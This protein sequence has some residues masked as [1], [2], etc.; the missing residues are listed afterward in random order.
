M[1]VVPDSRRTRRT[2]WRTDA[3]RLASSE[4]NGSSS[5]TSAGSMARPRASATRCCWPP[6]SSC[7]NR[8]ARAHRVRPS[9]AAQRRADRVGPAGRGRSRRSPRRDK[10]GKRLP[11]LRDVADATLRRLDEVRLVVDARRRAGRSVRRSARSKPAITR[12]SVVLPL[13][14]G[15]R[16]D[17]ERAGLD[18]EVEV[19]EHRLRARTPCGVLG[20]RVRS[21]HHGSRTWRRTSASRQ[22]VEEPAD[23]VRGHRGDGDD[24]Q[25]E[26]RRLAV[27]EVLLVRPELRGEGLDTGRDEDQRRRELGHRREED[28]AEGGAEPGRDEREC[29]AQQDARRDARRANPRPPRGRPAPGRPRRARPPGR[30]GRTSWRRRRSSIGAVWYAKAVGVLLGEVRQRE[31]DD[32]AGHR[33]DEEGRPREQAVPT[34]S[35][36]ERRAARAAA[37]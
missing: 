11:V 32:E 26:R 12:R 30:A 36:S 27:G 21:C 13:P 19:R 4:E 7:G 16:I 8:C 37:P 18:L 9:P 10:C 23:Q 25:R 14:D 20:S 5:S 29:D 35:G 6:E 34:A 31:R 17:D 1:A 2:S 33:E 3:R 28:Q 24:E 22:A 15:P